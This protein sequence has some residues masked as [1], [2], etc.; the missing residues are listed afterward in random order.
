MEL[1]AN[2]TTNEEGQVG[3]SPLRGGGQGIGSECAV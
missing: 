2:Q 3:G 1:V